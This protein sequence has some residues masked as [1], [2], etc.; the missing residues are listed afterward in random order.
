[1]T[2]PALQ[3]PCPLDSRSGTGAR[4]RRAHECAHECARECARA[5]PR[6]PARRRRARRRSEQHLFAGRAAD[7]AA[8]SLTYRGPIG[9]TSEHSQQEWDETNVPHE[10]D[11][12]S[13]CRSGRSRRRRSFEAGVHLPRSP[14][15]CGAHGENAVRHAS[16]AGRYVR[17]MDKTPRRQ[18]PPPRGRPALT[19]W[20]GSGGRD[21]DPKVRNPDAL[22]R[23]R[24]MMTARKGDGPFSLDPAVWRAS[25]EIAEAVSASVSASMMYARIV[26]AL[27]DSR[28]LRRRHDSIRR[29]WRA[30]VERCRER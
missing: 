17:T 5:G 1:M 13:H 15:P 23:T 22:G 21:G 9:G 2:L 8:R 4:Q 14:A 27:D 12:A 19:S 18:R 20:L 3:L 26:S 30:M 16:R 24:S 28:R 7:E 6:T 11:G 29:S 10:S 25:G